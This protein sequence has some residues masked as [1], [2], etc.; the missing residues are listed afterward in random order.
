MNTIYA[1]RRP[2]ALVDALLIAVSVVLA[3][4]GAAGERSARFHLVVTGVGLILALVLG[5]VPRLGL[6]LTW[7]LP[8]LAGLLVAAG[9]GV[10]VVGTPASKVLAGLAVLGLMGFALVAVVHK[11]DAASEKPVSRI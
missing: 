10:G 8:F 3:Q 7:L 1:R 5:G 11:V 4:T 2:L 9:A 6:N